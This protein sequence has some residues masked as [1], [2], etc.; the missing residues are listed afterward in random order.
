VLRFS[1]LE[2]RNEDASNCMLQFFSDLF[3]L[4]FLIKLFEQQ[5]TQQ[6]TRVNFQSSGVHWNCQLKIYKTAESL[7]YSLQ[8]F[9][10]HRYSTRNSKPTFVGIPMKKITFCFFLFDK[11]HFFATFFRKLVQK[12]SQNTLE[13]PL[14]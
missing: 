12:V 8:L 1:P 4:R 11:N 6:V 14:I 9:R 10:S 13:K 5:R 2:R 3:F 7:N